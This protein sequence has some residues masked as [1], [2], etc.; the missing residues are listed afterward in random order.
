MIKYPSIPG[1]T[2]LKLKQLV[3]TTMSPHQS[4]SNLNHHSTL[5]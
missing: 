1:S 2:F 3:M 4:N 5:Y